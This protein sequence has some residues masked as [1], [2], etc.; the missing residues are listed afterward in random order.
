MIKLNFSASDFTENSAY[1][2]LF[3]GSDLKFVRFPNDVLRDNLRE[4]N[5]YISDENGNKILVPEV[6]VKNEYVD[7]DGNPVSEIIVGASAPFDGYIFLK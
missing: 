4:A 7:E 2:S 1:N 3:S 5:A 6:T